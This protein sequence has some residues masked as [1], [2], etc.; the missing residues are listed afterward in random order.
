[1]YSLIDIKCLCKI[2]IIQYK[3]LKYQAAKHFS[4]LQSDIRSNKLPFT[5][6]LIVILL[7]YFNDVHCA[8]CTRSRLRGLEKA[9]PP[10]NHRTSFKRQS[11]F[12]YKAV[13]WKITSWNC[14]NTL[15]V[16]KRYHYKILTLVIS[17]NFVL[18]WI[19]SFD[20]SL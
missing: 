2:Y 17:L 1:M 11:C 10:E 19:F 4:I 8:R 15:M 5:S 6:S 3:I 7:D 9:V 14:R 12:R 20:I 18:N 16:Y 13:V